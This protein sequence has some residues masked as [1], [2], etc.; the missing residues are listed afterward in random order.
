VTGARAKTFAL[1]VT[2][3]ALLSKPSG[4]SFFRRI[5][6]IVVGDWQAKALHSFPELEY[7]I[8]RNQSGPSGVWTD[9]YCALVKA[10]E[11]Q[12]INED[13]IARI[14]DYAAWCFRQPQTEDIETD[15]SSATAVGFIENLPLDHRVSADLFR[16]LS[17]ETFEGCERLF[18][19]HLSDKEYEEFHREFMRRKMEFSGPSRL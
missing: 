6:R 19:Y 5:A 13:L 1:I 14:Y 16:W 9:L 3:S 4:K 11:E 2:R 12:P 18:K 10:Y 8:N 17:A 15:L 7:E